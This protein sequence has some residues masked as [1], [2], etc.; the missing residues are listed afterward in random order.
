MSR[1][2]RRWGAGGRRRDLGDGDGHD[3]GH[4]DTERFDVGG[5]DVGEGEEEYAEVRVDTTPVPPTVV[6]LVD[7]SGSME[8][9]FAGKTRW[10]AVSETLMDPVDGVVK[11]L[12][13]LLFD[14]GPRCATRAKPVRGW[15]AT[16][17][18]RTIRTLEPEVDRADPAEPEPETE[19]DGSAAEGQDGRSARA[20]RRREARRDA[21]LEAAKCVFQ[22]HGFHEASVQHI[23]AEAEIARGT[24]Y[25]YF[26]S[27]RDVFAEILDEFV[28]L[29]RERVRRI[30]LD[31]AQGT[32]LEQLRD[33]FRRV[34]NVVVDHADV[35]SIM[36]RDPSA[37]D[38]ETR[39]QAIRFDAQIQG[40][41]EG[42]IRVGQQL[43]VI[44][45]CDVQ[46]AAI[47]AFGGVRAA[48]RQV[49]EA[50]AAG[51]RS[52]QTDPDRVADQMMAFIIE[53]LAEG[54]EL[55]GLGKARGGA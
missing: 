23:I 33:T 25:L 50:R 36:L 19:E 18:G 27:K 45:Q 3:H 26:S 4:G 41:V 15:P 16:R 17:A 42:A 54:D 37:F 53:G 34:F 47:A 29:I 13:R 51:E 43:G 12:G 48:L 8:A 30:S 2:S 6:L 39:E 46:L 44:R 7:Q 40:M 31:P 52:E 22:E 21:I 11:P 14:R 49:L 5:A 28:A 10:S 35:A 38:E 20:Q 1:P 55:R 32:P 24:F 9:D